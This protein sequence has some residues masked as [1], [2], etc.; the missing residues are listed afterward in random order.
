M[1]GGCHFTNCIEKKE[2]RTFSV[3][4]MIFLVKYKEFQNFASTLSK[5][6]LKGSKSLFYGK[7]KSYEIMVI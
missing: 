2:I 6:Q 5:M 1:R 4:L 3:I 7:W